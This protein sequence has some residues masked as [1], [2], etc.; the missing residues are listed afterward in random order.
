MKLDQYNETSTEEEE[1]RNSRKAMLT[2]YDDTRECG[3]ANGRIITISLCQESD[4]MG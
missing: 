1:G 2:C 4:C 3:E